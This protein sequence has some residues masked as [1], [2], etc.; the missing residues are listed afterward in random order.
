M[1]D[2]KSQAEESRPPGIAEGFRAWGAQVSGHC[3][4]SVGAVRGTGA[5]DGDVWP[6]YTMMFG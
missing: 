5:E 1:R 4:V 2:S 6:R 3:H